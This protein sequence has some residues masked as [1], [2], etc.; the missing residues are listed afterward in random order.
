MPAVVG[1]KQLTYGER[2]KLFRSKPKEVRFHS[3]NLIN[4]YRTLIESFT[5]DEYQTYEKLCHGHKRVASMLK[6]CGHRGIVGPILELATIRSQDLKLHQKLIQVL[7]YRWTNVYDA[8]K[9][10]LN[11]TPH[12]FW[13]KMA[14]AI[15]RRCRE[16]NMELHPTWEG[17]KGK[18]LLIDFLIV[19]YENQKGLCAISQEPMTLTTGTRRTNANKCSPDRKNSNKGYTPSNLWFVTWWAN[20]MKM[21]MPMITFWKRVDTLA[22]SRKTRKEE[23]ANKA[24]Y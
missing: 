8:N 16:E 15:Q 24:H 17:P 21:D 12:M 2:I 13:N 19:Q 1:R 4:D 14:G 20:S 23:Y 3:S 18:E 7:R 5:K 6:Y 11:E 22:E 9:A 10:K